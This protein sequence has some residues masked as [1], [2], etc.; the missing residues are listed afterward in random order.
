MASNRL[1]FHDEARPPLSKFGLYALV[2]FLIALIAFG[3]WVAAQDAGRTA[4]KSAL[5]VTLHQSALGCDRNQIQRAYL[6]I[7][8]RDRAKN[9]PNRIALADSYFRT[10]NCDAT[11]SGAAKVVFLNSADDRCFL[12]LTVRGEWSHRLATTRPQDLHRLC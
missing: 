1:K 6:R 12:K 10:I 7:R 3:S 5:T 9:S 4:A 11:W 8:A 2:T